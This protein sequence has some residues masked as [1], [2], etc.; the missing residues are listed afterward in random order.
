MFWLSFS[1]KG[2]A[3]IDDGG[4]ADCFGLLAN[5]VT[6]LVKFLFPS[7]VVAPITSLLAFSF[8]FGV[9]GSAFFFLSNKPNVKVEFT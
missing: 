4:A 9:L 1:L 3:F 2:Y 5:G 6:I 8:G 7:G